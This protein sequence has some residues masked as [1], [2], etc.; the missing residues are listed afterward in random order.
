MAEADRSVGQQPVV[1]SADCREIYS[2]LAA[3]TGYK[4]PGGSFINIAFAAPS[5]VNYTNE[6]G[7][8]GAS[9]VVLKKVGSVTMTTS[10][11]EA[12]YESLGKAIKK[13]KEATGE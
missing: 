7:Q 4:T 9:K 5:V 10:R 13:H 1:E 2:E 6:K 12:L 8:P 3:I 11:A